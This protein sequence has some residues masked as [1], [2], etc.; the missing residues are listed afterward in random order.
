VSRT[1][2][3]SRSRS[4]TSIFSPC[5]RRRSTENKRAALL[6][7]KGQIGEQR[8]AHAERGRSIHRTIATRFHAIWSK[9]TSQ[10]VG[11]KDERS[12]IS[13]HTRA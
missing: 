11:I 1:L 6:K 9:S 4:E 7:H 5:D 2:M 13:I 12:G 8:A 3:P 10:R